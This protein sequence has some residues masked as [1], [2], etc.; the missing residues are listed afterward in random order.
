MNQYTKA[1]RE[2]DKIVKKAERYRDR[3][4]YRENLG[5]DQQ[6]KVSIMLGKLTLTYQEECELLDY[7][8]NRCNHI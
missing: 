1:K 2:I 3:Y 7:F 8:T 5:Y 4:G 6:P